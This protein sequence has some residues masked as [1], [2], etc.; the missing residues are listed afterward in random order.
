MHFRAFSKYAAL[1]IVIQ[2]VIWLAVSRLD[3]LEVFAFL[4]YPTVWLVERFGNFTGEANIIMPIVIG[5]P[6]GIV[7]YSIILAAILTTLKR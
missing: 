2:C 1:F 7:A 6:I 5:V 4:Y 3:L